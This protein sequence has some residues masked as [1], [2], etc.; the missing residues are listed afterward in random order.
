VQYSVFNNSIIQTGGTDTQ[1]EPD[2]VALVNSVGKVVQFLSYEG[3][4]VA[5]NGA[6]TNM[7]STDVGVREKSTTPIGY[8]L[9][10][11]PGNGTWIGPIP[12]TRGRP[13]LIQ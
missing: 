9:Q 7:S 5:L 12:N 11:S 6:A 2:G 13:N 10:L 4:F 8:S 1:S 3:S